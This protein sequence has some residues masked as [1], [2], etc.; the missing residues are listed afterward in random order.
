MTEEQAR[1]VIIRKKQE[2]G[3]RL[4]ILAYSLGINCEDMA[5][6]TLEKLAA[7]ISNLSEEYRVRVPE[8]IAADARVAL[9]RMLEV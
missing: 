2:L 4:V 1:N 3:S 7:C 8:D 6:I 9:R 5:K